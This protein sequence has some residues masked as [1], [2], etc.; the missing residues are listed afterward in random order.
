MFEVF[1]VSVFSLQMYNDFGHYRMLQDIQTVTTKSNK[2][3]SKGRRVPELNK[4]G[5][6]ALDPA[7]S[8]AVPV[9]EM[10]AI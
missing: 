10:Q 7:S 1:S 2:C 6:E 5:K 4:E 9:P 8:L 3:S